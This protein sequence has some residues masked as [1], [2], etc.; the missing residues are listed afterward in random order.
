M[1]SQPALMSLSNGFSQDEPS[2]AQNQMNSRRGNERFS[3]NERSREG[4]MMSPFE[5]KI[6]TY[7]RSAE[8]RKQTGERSGSRQ[9]GQ[10]PN[11]SGHNFYPVPNPHHTL[12][13]TNHNSNQDPY[14][15]HPQTIDFVGGNESP[16][17]RGLLVKLR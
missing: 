7:Q 14:A 10:Q 3:S 6:A 11:T 2:R 13:V 5:K 17:M 4:G 9:R 8:R 1:G 15:Q 12:A 16:E